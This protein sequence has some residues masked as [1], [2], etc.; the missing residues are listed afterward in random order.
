MSTSS[1]SRRK[2]ETSTGMLNKMKSLFLSDTQ[3]LRLSNVEI[4]LKASNKLV[5]G[6]KITNEEHKSLKNTL[7]YIITVLRKNPNTV[8]GDVSHNKI[9]V[10]LNLL[11]D[12]CINF[13]SGGKYQVLNLNKLE[14]LIIQLKA[15]EELE[16]LKKDKTCKGEKKI[17]LIE[18]INKRI[19]L[20]KP[21]MDDIY[22]YAEL[23]PIRDENYKQLESYLKDE[24]AIPFEIFNDS[25][26]VLLFNKL[27]LLIKTQ[28]KNYEKVLLFVELNKLNILK[29]Y[30]D[31][32]ISTLSNIVIDDP[33]SIT[34]LKYLKELTPKDLKDFIYTIENLKGMISKLENNEL[35]FLIYN[36]LLTVEELE[37]LKDKYLE[38]N[39]LLKLLNNIGES[40][41]YDILNNENILLSLEELLK[42]LK[43]RNLSL[44]NINK[45]F[46]LLNFNDLSL[47]ELLKLLKDKKISF[48]NFEHI[49]NLKKHTNVDSLKKLYIEG[50]ISDYRDNKNNIID[51]K[52][53]DLLMPY[54]N[55]KIRNTKE[56]TKETRKSFTNED[57][58]FIKKIYNSNRETRVN[59]IKHITYLENAKKIYDKFSDH[60]SSDPSLSDHSSSDPSSSDNSDH[61]EDEKRSGGRKVL[62]VKK[63]I[64][65]KL[66]CIYKIPGS[67]KEHIK[68]KGRLITVTE[69]KKLMKAK[70]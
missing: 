6:R 64:C 15:F 51:N 53:S 45:P 33:P 49:F 34:K 23:K 35:E 28:L 12:E 55:E 69:Y 3:R 68:Y 10:N 36:N 44:N 26:L 22:A 50:K 57:L 43:D 39:K 8:T 20:T 30:N 9:F 17:F 59:T 2:S 58:Q 40:K 66:R 14:V 70:S 27:K 42:L 25:E 54:F 63:E 16:K 32:Y 47:E 4:F 41:L 24:S 31:K 56:F 1:F 52:I 29:N 18:L 21:M 48:E 5:E 67:R 11:F 62:S 60:S 46:L 13:I 7:E 19:D 38:S 37:I 65:G 61:S